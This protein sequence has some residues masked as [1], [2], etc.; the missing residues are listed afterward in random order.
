MIK[1]FQSSLPHGSDGLILP[2]SYLPNKISIL[3]P[4]RERLD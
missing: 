4:S 2:L 1:Q 3:A